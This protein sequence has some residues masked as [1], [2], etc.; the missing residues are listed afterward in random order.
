SYPAGVCVFDD[1][2]DVF[3]SE[4]TD[5]MNSGIDIHQV[6]VREFLSIQLPEQAGQVAVVCSLLMRVLAISKGTAVGNALFERRNASVS[7]EIGENRRIVVR[8]YIKG[9]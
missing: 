7:V 1:R 4:F 3:V 2:E 9:Q 5:E 6:V 8:C